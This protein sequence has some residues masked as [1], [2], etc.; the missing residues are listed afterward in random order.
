M[1]K[2]A[3]NRKGE[4]A[5]VAKR[6]ATSGSFKPGHKINV[7]NPGPQRPSFLTQALI[8]QLNEIDKNTGREKLH[9][10]AERLLIHAFG[11]EYTI[12]VTGRKNGKRIVVD[13]ELSA[14]KEVFDRVQG[15]AVQGVAFDPGD[16]I[17]HVHFDEADKDA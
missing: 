13:G 17:I 11:G 8:S 10:L 14:I 4:A 3:Q 5:Q 16:G 12:K 9:M 6:L 7:G 15:R 1:A 2:F